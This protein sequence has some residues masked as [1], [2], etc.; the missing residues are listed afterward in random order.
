MSLCWAKPQ[1]SELFRGGV[2]EGF[3]DMAW[4]G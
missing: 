4:I 2:K 1:S 3:V